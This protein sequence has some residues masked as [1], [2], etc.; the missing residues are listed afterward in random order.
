MSDI[1]LMIPKTDYMPHQED[2]NLLDSILITAGFRD[3][4]T[5]SINEHGFRRYFLPAEEF[6]AMP[7]CPAGDYPSEDYMD[8]QLSM[9]MEEIIPMEECLKFASYGIVFR[10]L[11]VVGDHT[12]RHFS[13][14]R[15]QLVR[16]AQMCPEGVVRP[17][18]RIV[19]ERA[20]FKFVDR[21]FVHGSDLT[22][23]IETEWEAN[24]MIQNHLRSLNFR[25]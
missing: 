10:N 15:R 2:Y 3:E 16:L 5:I 17:S 8:S 18:R 12:L 9:Y 14:M 22:D 19:E 20:Y 24:D 6:D 1:T 21:G 25:E 11:R 7:A 4:H 13:I 23:W